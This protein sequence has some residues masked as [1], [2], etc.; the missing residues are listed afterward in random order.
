MEKGPGHSVLWLFHLLLG[1][2]G[3]VDRGQA[4]DMVPLGHFSRHKTE[5]GEM[6]ETKEGQ[7]GDTGNA[8]APVKHASP[9]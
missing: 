6:G 1:L 7:S 3:S 2:P 8:I 5:A 4:G 9:F